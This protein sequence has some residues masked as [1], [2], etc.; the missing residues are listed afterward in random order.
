MTK[1]YI[2]NEQYLY[3]TDEGESNFTIP[4]DL[5]ERYHLALLEWEA[6]QDELQEIYKGNL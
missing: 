3:L 4:Q 6:V 5:E 2:D 1:L